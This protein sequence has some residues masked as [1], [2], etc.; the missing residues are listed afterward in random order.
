MSRV[1][2]NSGLRDAQS[3]TL[4]MVADP[5]IAVESTEHSIE[6]VEHIVGVC[7]GMVHEAAWLTSL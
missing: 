4:P 2:R 1:T 7:V 5:A 3:V 6:Q